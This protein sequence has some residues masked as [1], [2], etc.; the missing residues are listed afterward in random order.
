MKVEYVSMKVFEKVLS[1]ILR[2]VEDARETDGLVALGHLTDLKGYIEGIREIFTNFE[3][4][5]INQ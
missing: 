5:S 3:A 2:K 4:V 1:T